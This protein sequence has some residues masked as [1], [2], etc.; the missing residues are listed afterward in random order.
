M[1]TRQR[2]SQY[3][4]LDDFEQAARRFLPRSLFA[5]VSGGVETDSTLRK[6]RQVFQRYAFV[7]RVMR[8]VSAVC[9]ET[10]LFGVRYAA[11]IGIAP[12]GLSALTAWRG[13]RVQAQA[14]VK[15]GIPMILS[16]SSLT[17]LEDIASVGSNIWF[18]AYLP[19][20]W[21]QIEALLH[22]VAHAGFET[23][24][25]TVDTPVPA[26][27]ENN[28]RAGFTAPLRPS[29]RLLCDGL[30]HPRWTF[31]VFL[32]TLLTDGMPHFENN[33]ATRGAPIFSRQVLRDFS[34]RAHL[35]WTYFKKVRALWSGK[36]VLKGV[37]APADARTAVALGADGLIVSNHGGRQ[38]DG[39]ITP[40]EVLPEIV[41]AC[42][43]VPVM[44]DSGVRRG[45]DVLKAMALGAHFVFVGRPFNYAAAV[46]GQAGVL[47]AIELLQQEIRR[48][49]AM[50]G[51]TD[52][53]ALN[54][55]FVVQSCLA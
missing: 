50:L 36:I 37:L 15:A 22:R 40:L 30:L 45:S 24:V 46:A 13:D 43:D 55:E 7:P 8:D 12:M 5:Y 26:N 47:H 18:Q 41:S 54:E 4:N 3:L 33:Y 16:G 38:L 20:Q 28:M 39:V 11:P 1:N 51:V 49:L 9:T 53:A 52:L 23:L 42:P 32:R 34:D 25:I 29:I 17:P 19:G 6:N 44:M 21:E 10:A 35:N 14:A 27:R 2:M 48:N 31:G